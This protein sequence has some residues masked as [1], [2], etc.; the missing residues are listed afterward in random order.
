M[1]IF[2]SPLIITFSPQMY[3]YNREICAEVGVCG[4]GGVKNWEGID[5]SSVGRLDCDSDRCL[6]NCEGHSSVTAQSQSGA[7]RAGAESAAV[8]PKAYLHLSHPAGAWRR[9]LSDHSQEIQV[10]LIT[11]LLIF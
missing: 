3:L 9:S 4:R 1:H 5:C 10:G 11:A 8:T 7:R 6:E 2:Y